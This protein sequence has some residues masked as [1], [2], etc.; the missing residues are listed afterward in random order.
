MK[1]IKNY[2]YN[3]LY[4][5]LAV[6]LPFITIPYVSRVLGAENVGINS[7]T[8]AN[9]Q[10]FVLIATMGISVYAT[11]EIA[12]VKNDANARSALFFEIMVIKLILFVLAYGLFFIFLFLVHQYKQIYI[13][14]SISIVSAFFD[15]SWFFMG[16]QNFKV[17]VLRNLLVK[18]ISIISI[19]IFVKSSN[20]IHVYILILVLSIFFGNISIWS[21]LHSN[22]RFVKKHKILSFKRHV[23]PIVVLFVPQVA[24][25][26][27][28]VV[29]KTILGIYS[30]PVSLGLFENSD[31]IIRIL[32][33]VVTASGMVLLPA[34]S[35]LYANKDFNK[36][37][38]YMYKAFDYVSFL[39]I[40]LSVGLIV[41]AFPFGTWFFGQSFSNIG[42][43]LAL[44]SS[45]LVF[46]AWNNTLSSQFLIPAKHENWYTKSFIYGA[47]INIALNILFDKKFGAVGAAISAVLSET[48]VVIYQLYKIKYF[49]ELKTMFKNVWKYYFASMIMA[50]GV[51]FINKVSE[52]NIFVLILDLTTGIIIYLTCIILLRVSIIGDFKHYIMGKLQK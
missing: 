41:V 39:S 29:N 15:I 21:Y 27:F 26:V 25:Q 19:F 46:M 33:A 6:L 11:R 51:F 35:N 38:E 2:I 32:M 48:I 47:I 24:I 14:Q 43:V 9:T 20:D 42:L 12:Y 30:T 13:I 1:I 31:K 40:P 36:V 50:V 4:Q 17:T 7:L 23:K 8:N 18:I 28:T 22:L 34:V 3:V 37:K 52:F 45:V 5:L 49:F 16:L 44:L 10:Y